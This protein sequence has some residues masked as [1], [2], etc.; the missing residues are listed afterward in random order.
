M[1]TES[2][3]LI[4]DLERRARGIQYICK[5]ELRVPMVCRCRTFPNVNEKLGSRGMMDEIE[6]EAVANSRHRPLN[7]AL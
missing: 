3:Y 4:F 6:R 1:G 7:E 5:E 2:L